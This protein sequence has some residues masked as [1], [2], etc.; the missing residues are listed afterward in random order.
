MIHIEELAA[1]AWSLESRLRLPSEIGTRCLQGV[2]SACGVGG[3]LKGRSSSRKLNGQLRRVAALVLG[4]GLEPFYSWI[5]TAN[6]PADAPSSVYGIRASRAKQQPRSGKEQTEA[7]VRAE[8]TPAVGQFYPEKGERLVLHLF[9]GPRRPGDFH[10]AVEMLSAQWGSPLRVLSLD[11]AAEPACDLGQTRVRQELL[12]LVASGRVVGVLAG[13]P[14]NT[15]SAA[16]HRSVGPSGP[17]PLRGRRDPWEPLPNLGPSE[18]AAVQRGSELA[19]LALDV[20]GACASRGGW[21][22]VEHPADRGRCPFPSLW[23][24]SQAR[25]MI[26]QCGFQRIRLDQ[27]CYG[28]ASCKPTELLASSPAL[29][30]L[31]CRCCHK[32]GHHAR[33]IGVNRGVFRTHASAQYPAALCSAF[34]LSA[35]AH[36]IGA[37]HVGQRLAPQGPWD[38]P[39][40]RG[41]FPVGKSAREHSGAVHC[42]AAQLQNGLPGSADRLRRP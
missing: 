8:A 32:P 22:V 33:L 4:G 41:G 19:L 11:T 30:S 13:P 35:V 2:D 7:V 21:A 14:C 16:R 39:R 28:A 1:V 42:R 40:G 5:P 23:N 9:S 12:D 26:Q 10:E 34:A 6:N 3:L 20:A 24:T 15:W 27:C 29:N 31:A 36:I 37:E 38:P 18:R 17:R 25:Y